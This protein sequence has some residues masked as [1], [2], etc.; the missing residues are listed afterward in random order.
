MRGNEFVDMRT[1][2]VRPLPSA[3]TLLGESY[4]DVTRHA[5]SIRAVSGGNG[6]LGAAAN[7]HEERE[8]VATE[9]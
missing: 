3:Q 8:D 5:R 9:P 6:T 4:S 7:G 1:R 2:A